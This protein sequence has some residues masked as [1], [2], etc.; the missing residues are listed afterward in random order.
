MK[1]IVML[2]TAAFLFSGVA[3]AQTAK[4]ED[5]KCAKGKD[6][7]KKDAATKSCSTKDAKSKTAEVK[8][9]KTTEAKKKA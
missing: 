3:F 5:K 2:A 9:L 7:C 8:S 4:K 6:C 1:K